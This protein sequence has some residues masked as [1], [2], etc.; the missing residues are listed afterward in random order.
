LNMAKLRFGFITLMQSLMKISDVQWMKI[1]FVTTMVL[2]CLS[3]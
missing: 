2:L 1:R 3:T